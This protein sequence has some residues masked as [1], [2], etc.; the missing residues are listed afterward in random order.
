MMG[1]ALYFHYLLV[2]GSLWLDS[3]LAFLSFPFIFLG[4]PLP[5][6]LILGSD[7][8]DGGPDGPVLR[9]YNAMCLFT[10]DYS[11]QVFESYRPWNED[12]FL[13]GNEEARYQYEEVIIT[14][15][16]KEDSSYLTFPFY[17][18]PDPENDDD[19]WIQ[20]LQIAEYPCGNERT[21]YSSEWQSMGDDT[22][23]KPQYSRYVD[24]FSHDWREE[25]LWTSWKCL[26]IERSQVRDRRRLENA[27]WRTWARVKNG[28]DTLPPSKLCW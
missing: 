3:V 13:L 23:V 21:T 10:Q 24:Y 5:V 6:R 15:A 11:T 7:G 27:L 4:H 28:L 9:L 2:T 18:D 25:D 22:M 20:C 17:D 26:A 19:D 12:L 8:A 14:D 1:K 16:R